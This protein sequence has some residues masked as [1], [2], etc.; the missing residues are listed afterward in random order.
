MSANGTPSSSA[1]P[2]ADCPAPRDPG[3]ASSTTLRRLVRAVA[4]AACG[5]FA[6]VLADGL[7]ASS[8][9][10]DDTAGTKYAERDGTR[11]IEVAGGRI[12]LVYDARDF[13]VSPAVIARWIRSSALATSTY[14]G[15]FPVR[16]VVMRLRPAEGDDV[17][18]GSATADPDPRIT[19]TIGR[20]T[21]ER[22]LLADSTAVHEM[23][24]LAIPDHAE[25]YLWFHEGIA[26][27]V[28]TIAR[29]QA[30]LITPER[31]WGELAHGMALGV[32]DGEE[33]RGL[34]RTE[35]WDR[36]YWG[37]AIFFLLADIEMRRQSGGRQG[38]QDALRSLQRSGGNLATHWEFARILRTADSAI[39]RNVLQKL[40]VD[41]ARTGA[42]GRIDRA[43]LAGLW[44]ELGV[45]PTGRHTS[46]LDDSA[47]LA[48]V[49][50]SIT[51]KPSPPLLVAQPR[52]IGEGRAR[53]VRTSSWPV[54][55]RR[56][57][58]VR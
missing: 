54:L 37:G 7:V 57:E 40:Y 38:L 46:R 41:L 33:E 13:A 18:G 11:T 12:D 19:I 3:L 30:G 23:T 21:A 22:T 53:Q 14:F 34:D 16:R 24:H 32:V 43:M 42:P 44:R 1:S 39:G 28:E 8:D 47:R 55:M 10:W 6:V 9:P 36:R 50:R 2:A 25:R 49:R 51:D 27:Y 35:I 56:P 58:A 17:I 5:A 48:P 4:A 29:A 20:D 31:A 15:Q 52:E 45:A 26:T